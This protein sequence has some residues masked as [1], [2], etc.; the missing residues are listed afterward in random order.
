MLGG[1]G[2]D[3]T[4]DEV[5]KGT[6]LSLKI[7]PLEIK[8]TTLY[9]ADIHHDVIL[10]VPWL[11][12]HT[13]T[14]LDLRSKTIEINHQRIPIITSI[15]DTPNIEVVSANTFA[16]ICTAEQLEEVLIIF[17]NKVMKTPP[18]KYP[19]D[20]QAIIEEFKDVFPEGETRVK[21][22]KLPPGLPPD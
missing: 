1:A 15:A 12:D 4:F 13:P 6:I 20:I 11:K 8:Q 14:T 18:T 2:R 3:S 19:V 16:R 10:G 5:N 7:E 21:F 17:T 22:A 9:L